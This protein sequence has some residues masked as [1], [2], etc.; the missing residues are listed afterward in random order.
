MNKLTPRKWKWSI[1]VKAKD[2]SVGLKWHHANPE[3][4]KK[5]VKR[6]DMKNPGKRAAQNKAWYKAHPNYKKAW[7][8]KMKKANPKQW[9]GW[10]RDVKL[11]VAYGISLVEFNEMLKAQRGGCAVCKGPA[12][13]RGTFH[14]DHDHKTGAVRGLLCHSC[15]CA[16]GLMKEDVK[17][18]KKLIKYIGGNY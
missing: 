6:W 1:R 13:G 10:N 16:L 9:K 17:L 7:R 14:V 2:R 8:E 11:R 3:R 18:L 15:N 12:N 5:I 4:A